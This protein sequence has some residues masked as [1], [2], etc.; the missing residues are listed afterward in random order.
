MLIE[1]L[2]SFF[3]PYWGWDVPWEALI[4]VT[5]TR[6]LWKHRLFIV[7]ISFCSNTLTH[8]RAFLWRTIDPFL[9]GHYRMGRGETNSLKSNTFLPPKM[10]IWKTQGLPMPLASHQPRTHFSSRLAEGDPALQAVVLAISPVSCLGRLLFGPILPLCYFHSLTI[11]FKS[12]FMSPIL[13][14]GKC[15]YFF[16]LPIRSFMIILEKKNT[17]LCF[18][19]TVLLSIWDNVL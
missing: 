18:S 5:E 9:V 3:G 13:N 14:S 1:Y 2:G 11:R 8:Y 12:P 4:K 19:S 6:T 17:L 10:N 16:V 7:A 15:T